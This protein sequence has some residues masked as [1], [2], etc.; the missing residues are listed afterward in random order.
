MKAHVLLSKVK[1]II[2]MY[3]RKQKTPTQT[4]SVDI[5]TAMR[6]TTPIVTTA[7]IITNTSDNQ[8]FLLRSLQGMTSCA[9]QI[10]QQH[11]I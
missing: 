11:A 5:V 7:I 4:M 10:K 6:A 1:M 3:P 2:Y 8:S 9:L